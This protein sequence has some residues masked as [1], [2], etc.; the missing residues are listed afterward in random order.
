MSVDE[1]LSLREATDRPGKEFVFI[2]S[3]C[4]DSTARLPLHS[5]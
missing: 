1:I 4:Q 2:A 3:P 5:R